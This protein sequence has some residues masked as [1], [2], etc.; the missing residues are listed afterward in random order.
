MR[1]IDPVAY[2]TDFLAEFVDHEESLYGGLIEA[3]TRAAPLE[4]PREPGHEYVAAIDPA[5]RGNAWT[6]VIATRTGRKKRIALARQWQGSKAAPLRPSVVL[7]EVA[8]LCA[9][10]G[11]TWAYTDQ[12]AADPLRDL[13][14][15]LGL[16]LIVEDWT[17]SNK[18]AAHLALAAELGEGFVELPPDQTVSKDL[19]VVRKRVTQAGIAIDLP[20][21]S[22]GRHAD[23]AAA[24]AKCLHRW[25]EEDRQVMPPAGTEEYWRVRER[26]DIESEIAALQEA[27]DRPWWEQT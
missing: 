5:T 1:R 6:L 26:Q 13:A 23:Y 3:N 22:D 15:P 8:K 17:S 24:V 16:D 9:G 12:W 21:T 18:S 20:Q 25:I 4:L 27:Q 14:A 7:A 11:L 10:Y 2:Q 19:R